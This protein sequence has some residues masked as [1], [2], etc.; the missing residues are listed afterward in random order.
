MDAFAVALAAGLTL[1]TVTHRHLFRF[2]FHFGLFQGMMPV[3]GWM[4]GVGLRH[5]M[6]AISH[7]L[8]FV[9]L[10]LIGVKM[11][12]DA[13]SHADDDS[14]RKD[15]TRGMSL[16]ML[17]IAT[18]IDALAVGFS[19]A[20]LGVSIWLPALVIGAT[21]SVF[22]LGGM[23]I[24]QRLGTLWSSKVECAGGLLLIAIGLKILLENTVFK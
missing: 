17:S 15:P 8:A 3:L 19:L 4:A 12:Y 5:Y 2:G 10:S 9:L 22:T 16:V 23:L 11:L 1:A 21:A 18:S 24:G 6:E 14:E 20:L 7:W 13:F